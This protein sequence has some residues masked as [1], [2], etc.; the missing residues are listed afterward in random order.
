MREIL[1]FSAAWCGP[2]RQLGPTME[3]LKDQI[4]YKKID[5]D[6]DTEHT[7]KYGV[8]NIPTLIFLE[9]GQEKG[10]LVGNQSAQTLLDFYNG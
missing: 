10:R 1:Y 9:D 3:R 6:S 7:V 5:V 4:N 2:C 8:R